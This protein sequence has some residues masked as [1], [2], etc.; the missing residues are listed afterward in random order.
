MDFVN[1]VYGF[2]HQSQIGFEQFFF[3]WFAGEASAER[4]SRSPLA[5]MYTGDSFAELRRKIGAYE[6]ID[7]KLLDHAYFQREKPCSLLIDEIESLWESI[8][9]RDDWSPFEAKLVQIE[10][11]RGALSYS[12][13]ATG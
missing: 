5:D 12:H 3:D 11:M 7:S 10:E 8:A 6:P 9:S 13:S 4:A 1:S 2:L